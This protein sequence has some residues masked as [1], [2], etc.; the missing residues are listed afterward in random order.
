MVD[1]SRV[2]VS[3]ALAPLS[4]GFV[5]ALAAVGYTPHGAVK[6]LR[7]FARLSQWLEN[8][9]LVLADLDREVIERFFSDRR[10]AGYTKLV[11][12]RAAEPLIAYLRGIGVVPAEV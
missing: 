7:L 2:R 10:A 9:D 3:G 1:L 6:Q 8:E 12:A 4:D 5:V 11:S